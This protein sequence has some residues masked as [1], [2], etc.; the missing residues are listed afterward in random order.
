MPQNLHKKSSSQG[1]SISLPQ[2]EQFYTADSMWVNLGETPVFKGCT[3][4]WSLAKWRQ[5]VHTY[6]SEGL[7]FINVTKRI[8]V[9][10][11]EVYWDLDGTLNGTPKSYTTWADAFNL[12][13]PGCKYT[14]VNLNVTDDG[15]LEETTWY[16]DTDMWTDDPS[17]FK[18]TLEFQHRL[19]NNTYMTCTTPIRKLNIAWPEPQEAAE[20]S[21][22]VGLDQRYYNKASQPE[23]RSSFQW[24]CNGN[25]MCT[26]PTE[27]TVQGQRTVWVLGVRV[28]SSETRQ[29][30]AP[31][32]VVTA[33]R[34]FD[35]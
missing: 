27:P 33:G 5:G 2:N 16:S 13:H 22:V 11:K 10:K 34:G 32:L 21:G 6:R 9:H 4:C 3:K 20:R 7:S 15:G 14:H 23:K 12:G 24:S 29:E 19:R 18:A 28:E 26:G 17:I 35:L 1:Q 8:N 30:E 31:P 25:Y